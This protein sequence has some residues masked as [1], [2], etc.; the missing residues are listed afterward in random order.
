MPLR[1]L[2][3]SDCLAAV[4][5]N[6]LEPRHAAML[7]CSSRA[8]RRGITD[9]MMRAAEEHTRRK[10]ATPQLLPDGGVRIFTRMGQMHFDMHPLVPA[11][12]ASLDTRALSLV[13]QNADALMTGIKTPMY[14][15]R[16]SRDPTMRVQTGSMHFVRT[17]FNSHHRYDDDA[18]LHFR[19]SVLEQGNA[20]ALLQ[21]SEVEVRIAYM[22]P[23][24]TMLRVVVDIPT[25]KNEGK[26]LLEINYGFNNL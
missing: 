18:D 9:T 5:C 10:Y 2:S 14:T 15:L 4:V 1:Q 24:G 7:R 16:L 19:C 8:L 26:T 13:Y 17:M 23:Q 3:D 11:Q 21:A 20:L 6:F 22:T 12:C 25:P